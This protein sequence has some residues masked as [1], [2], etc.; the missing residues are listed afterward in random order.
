MSDVIL[1]GSY[2]SYYTAKV[3]S[4]LRKKAIPFS[5]RLPSDPRFRAEVRPA[6]GSHRIPQVLLPDGRV[7]QD[8]VEILDELERLY[9]QVPAFPPTPCQ[10]VYTWQSPRP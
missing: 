1:Y 3:R 8:S 9:P 7:V 2:A 6:S 5:E 10:R 4:A